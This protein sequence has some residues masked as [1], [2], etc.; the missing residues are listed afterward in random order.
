MDAHG[1]LLELQ[2]ELKLLTDKDLT[3][4]G[5]GFAYD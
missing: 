5:V 1:L 4:V 2:D 3:H